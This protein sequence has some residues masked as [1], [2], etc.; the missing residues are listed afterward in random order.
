MY[1]KS[2]RTKY[3]EKGIMIQL[4]DAFCMMHLWQTSVCI[5]TKIVKEPREGWMY[6][7]LQLSDLTSKDVLGK[8]NRMF[9]YPQM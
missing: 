5:K 1:E 8:S 3:H 6:F 4:Y 7:D 9:P 2:V